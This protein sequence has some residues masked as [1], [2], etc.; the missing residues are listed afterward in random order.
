[1]WLRLRHGEVTELGPHQARLHTHCAWTA[2]AVRDLGTVSLETPHLGPCAAPQ[3]FTMF[4]TKQKPCRLPTPLP[5]VV[6]S[7]RLDCSTH[8]VLEAPYV[9]LWKLSSARGYFVPVL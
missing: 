4:R 6:S 8:T 3:S 7:G 2:A 9:R 1:M 5:S